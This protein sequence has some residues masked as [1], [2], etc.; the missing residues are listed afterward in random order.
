M[1]LA[2]LFQL[3]AGLNHTLKV[4]DEM[5]TVDRF[6]PERK[7]MVVYREFLRILKVV[8][9]VMDAL[10]IPGSALHNASLAAA[11]LNI[12]SFVEECDVIST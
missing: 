5:Q 9:D 6:V 11:L 1:L 4:P 8:Y 12:R 3:L 7:D 10:R 2:L